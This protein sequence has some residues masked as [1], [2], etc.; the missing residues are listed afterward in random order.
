[1]RSPLAYRIALPV[2]LAA[3]LVVLQSATSLAE[4]GTTYSDPV[5]GV[6]FVVPAALHSSAASPGVGGRTTQAI[7]STFARNFDPKVT[8]IDLT[9]ELTITAY[10]VSR[11]PNEDLRAFLARNAQGSPYVVADL[12]RLHG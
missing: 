8:T 9:R 2:L 1:M 6:S 4:V 12:P 10:V 3:A 7:F 5:T 11:A